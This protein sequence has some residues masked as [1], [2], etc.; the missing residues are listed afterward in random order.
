MEIASGEGEAASA[1]RPFICPGHDLRTTG[2][3]LTIRSRPSLVWDLPGHQGSRPG[4]EVEI[5]KPAIEWRGKSRDAAE[6]RVRRKLAELHVPMS[7]TPDV[8]LPHRPKPRLDL[9]RLRRWDIDC[10][11]EHDQAGACVD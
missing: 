1:A 6:H 10:L 7:P 4:C 3:R 5:E 2:V 9:F 11:M 8:R